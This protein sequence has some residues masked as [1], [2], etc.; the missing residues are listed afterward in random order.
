VQ[1]KSGS[2]KTYVTAKARAAAGDSDALLV[3]VI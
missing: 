2:G 3:N 1:R